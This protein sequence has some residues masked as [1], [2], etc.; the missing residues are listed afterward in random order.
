[1]KDFLKILDYNGKF[2]LHSVGKTGILA[3]AAIT[4]GFASYSTIVDIAYIS[5]ESH[6]A[7]II[8]NDGNTYNQMFQKSSLVNESPD[9]TIYIGSEKTKIVFQKTTLKEFEATG[10]YS[11]ITNEPLTDR[12]G[13]IFYSVDDNRAFLDIR[14]YGVKKPFETT[15]DP[16]NCIITG[17]DIAHKASDQSFYFEYNGVDNNSS[18]DEYLKTFDSK[19]L[20]TSSYT[21][22]EKTYRFD[23]SDDILL[24]IANDSSEDAYSDDFSI[25]I[26]TYFD[27]PTK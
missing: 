25:S 26:I 27:D 18:I 21:E 1:M 20:K 8:A 4:M 19:D 5:N 2:T 6:S 17:I 7:N 22:N 16:A 9:N 3:L 23:I 12:D 11:R 14:Y 13:L 15:I 10:K 24:Y